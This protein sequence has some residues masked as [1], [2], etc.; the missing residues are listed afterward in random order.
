MPKKKSGDVNGF[1]AKYAN[2]IKDFMPEADGMTPDGLKK[3]IIDAE[4]AIAEAERTRDSDQKLK[5]AREQV[6]DLSLGYKEIIKRQTARIRY[7][8][9]VLEGKGVV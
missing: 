6:K 8:L 1:P 2:L 3:A 5:D 4:N 9:M 7:A